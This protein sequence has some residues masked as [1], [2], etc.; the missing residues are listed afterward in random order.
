MKKIL[1]VLFILSAFLSGSLFAQTE[2]SGE[3]NARG[4]NNPDKIDFRSLGVRPTI[5]TSSLFGPK[6]FYIDQTLGS[7]IFNMVSILNLP[8][9]DISG[10]AVDYENSK[11][12]QAII[13]QD[14]RILLRQY[15]KPTAANQQNANLINN[16]VA[17]E[18]PDKPLDAG[19]YVAEIRIDNHLIFSMP[20]ELN[21]VRAEKPDAAIQECRTMDG[22]W[23]KY[24]F[25]NFNQAGVMIW[26]FYETNRDKK[27]KNSVR[28]GRV[29]T[30]SQ[31]L[32]KD[33]KPFSTKETDDHLTTRGDWSIFHAVF[34]SVSTGSNIKKQDLTDGQ[35][36]IKIKV[37]EE[38][39]EYPFT[40]KDGKIVLLEIQTKSKTESAA[41]KLEG[42]DSEFWV[43]RT[44]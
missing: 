43:Q 1:P 13:R 7:P 35:Y 24:G 16:N 40:V 34:S 32:F 12:I 20:F 11:H 8:L 37:D 41:T 42:M 33:G 23:S 5:V 9:T 28:D 44:K 15:L 14:D 30:V 19:N 17:M 10:K 27:V 22:L 29:Y 31:Q 25:I 36:L 38:E 4:K 3:V 2:K 26:N 21:V 39:R 6:G 18:K